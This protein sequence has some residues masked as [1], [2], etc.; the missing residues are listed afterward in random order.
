MHPAAS[1]PCRTCT[2]SSGRART[3]ATLMLHGCATLLP[4][5][6]GMTCFGQPQESLLVG[7]EHA[8]LGSAA[9]AFASS[10]AH[11][12]GERL[13][14]PRGD[15]LS[16]AS[17]ST[18]G[19][20]RHLRQHVALEP[21]PEVVDLP[22]HV[23]VSSNTGDRIGDAWLDDR[24]LRAWQLRALQLASATNVS[25]AGSASST[26]SFT[27]ID[28]IVLSFDVSRRSSS[29]SVS[30]W[31]AWPAPL[32]ACRKRVTSRAHVVERDGAARCVPDVRHAPRQIRRGRIGAGRVGAGDDRRGG[33]AERA[34]HDLHRR[35]RRA[36]GRR[37]AP[38]RS[39]RGDRRARCARPTR[40]GLGSR[41]GSRTLS[42]ILRER[43]RDAGR[44]EPEPRGD[45]RRARARR[46]RAATRS[47]CRGDPGSDR[48]RRRRTSRRW[49]TR[50]SDRT[51]SA[52][53][54]PRRSPARPRSPGES[55]ASSSGSIG[56][57]SVRELR[58]AAPDRGATRGSSAARDDVD[59]RRGDVGEVQRP[60]LEPAA[61]RGIQFLEAL[62]AR[63]TR[64]RP[65]RYVAG[66]CARC[67][68]ARYRRAPR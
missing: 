2:S 4:F 57:V 59:R 38:C 12:L 7:R 10:R 58:P 25:S 66:Q 3:R 24:H 65:A 46:R 29:S 68:A 6:A 36:A 67:R 14:A 48:C 62:T 51:S 45:V 42:A 41:A 49:N 17:S 37:G 61:V 31:L 33:V 47:P 56:G 23:D 13:G 54:R 55:G 20:G 22:R 28:S 52:E 44:L 50:S 5:S 40:I 8:H 30:A 32:R 1:A 35:L 39:S 9:P 18:F 64:P 21:R 43:Q 11:L 60:R 19:A 26:N 15:S 27:S 34:R 16:R 63:S 53:R